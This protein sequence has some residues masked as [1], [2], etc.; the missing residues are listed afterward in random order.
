[1]DNSPDLSAQFFQ[2]SPADQAIPTGSLRLDLALCAAGIQRGVII[3]ISG[4]PSSGKTTLCQHIIAQ[5]QK[6]G[7]LCAWIDADHTFDP[8][9]AKICGIQLEKLYFNEPTH[10][11]QALDILETLASSGVFAILVLDSLFTL[12]P[13]CELSGSLNRTSNS[14]NTYLLSCSLR[15][16]AG[17]LQR[18]G[19]SI[20]FT[21]L[22]KSQSSSIY[23]QLAGHT[24]RLALKLQA[25]QR[26]RLLPAR[27]L[28]SNNQNIGIRVQ[29]KVLK[30]RTVPFL[31]ASYFDIIH[32]QGINKS[33]EVLDLG[34][35][36][37]LIQK[38]KSGYT[39][40]SNKLGSSVQE[41]ISFLNQNILTRDSIEMEIRRRLI[42]EF[43]IAAT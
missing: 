18:T 19:T 16:L 22:T 8:V 7:S 11:E 14:E 26:L 37:R 23:H 17:L 40:G 42:P 2:R 21:D 38:Q 35:R 43:F 36:L 3:E 33:G 29:A 10:T 13:L 15:R 12:I 5:A 41:A 20:I 39:F 25:A 32:G 6:T 4:P 1:M 30:N 31:H 24:Y 28:I 9:Y 34:V 27:E